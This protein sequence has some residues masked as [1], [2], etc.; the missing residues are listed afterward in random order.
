MESENITVIHRGQRAKR[1]RKDTKYRREFSH[2]LISGIRYK[3]GLSV[4]ELCHRWRISRNTFSDWLNSIP[5][6]ARAYELS[7]VDYATYWHENFKGIVTGELK[8][9]AGSAIFAMT[10]IEEIKWASK[11]DV[12]NTSD[13]EVKKITIEL[14]PGRQTVLEHKDNDIEDAE[15]I[16]NNNV[17]KLISPEISPDSVTTDAS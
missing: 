16:N 4:V 14:L 11:V 8:G 2:Q 13:E 10:N 12:H 3:E 9:N 15:I 5:E 7:K 6:F 1:L 17:I